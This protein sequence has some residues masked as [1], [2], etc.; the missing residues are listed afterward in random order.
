VAGPWYRGLTQP[1]NLE[2][3]GHR[4]CLRCRRSNSA[5]NEP[6]VANLAKSPP[7]RT[8]TLQRESPQLLDLLLTGTTPGAGSETEVILKLAH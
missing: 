5:N 3:A 2:K 1:G 7:T 4:V 6:K 8:Q